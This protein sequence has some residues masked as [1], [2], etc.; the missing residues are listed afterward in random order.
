MFPAWRTKRVA[1]DLIWA[2]NYESRDRL[3]AAREL[4]RHSWTCSGWFLSKPFAD[5]RMPPG[6]CSII[7]CRLDWSLGLVP[8]KGEA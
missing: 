3:R 8:T 2:V 5:I 6:S 1:I 7:A 4:G